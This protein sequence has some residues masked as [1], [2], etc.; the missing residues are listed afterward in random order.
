MGAAWRRRGARWSSLREV[1]VGERQAP[2]GERLT[3]QPY[4]HGADSVK[5]TKLSRG[6]L[7]QLLE[8]GVSLGGEGAPSRQADPGRASGLVVVALGQG[9][10]PL[11]VYPREAQLAPLEVVGGLL[12]DPRG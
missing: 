12:A 9:D 10:R 8:A 1:R 3:Q 4:R 2:L 7:P 11:W 5:A 6:D